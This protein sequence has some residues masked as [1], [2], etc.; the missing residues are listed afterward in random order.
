MLFSCF[1]RPSVPLILSVGSHVPGA[2]AQP[3]VHSTSISSLERDFVTLVPAELPEK[4]LVHFLSSSSL[5]NLLSLQEG[6]MQ[7]G[8]KATQHHTASASSDI[9]LCYFGVCY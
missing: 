5:V 2:A 8:G 7:F 3:V 9:L 4:F 1:S 6:L